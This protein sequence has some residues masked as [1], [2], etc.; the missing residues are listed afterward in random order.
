[1]APWRER[2]CRKRLH[3]EALGRSSQPSSTT[4]PGTWLTPPR[5]LQSQWVP[6]IPC[7]TDR[8]IPTEPCPNFRCTESWENTIFQKGQ[9]LETADSGFC[10]T[11]SRVKDGA[12]RQVSTG[13]EVVWAR[14]ETLVLVLLRTWPR[15]EAA[16]TH[17][18]QTV[19]TFTHAPSKLVKSA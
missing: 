5:A 6:Q 12:R 1:M 3:G 18:W 14:E 11:I 7:G 9:D 16:Q 19:Q 17:R 2:P 10:N 15:S 8:N 4:A 13:R